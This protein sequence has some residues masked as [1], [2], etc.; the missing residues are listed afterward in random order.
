M[1]NCTGQ[2]QVVSAMTRM[3]AH[4]STCVSH[5][6]LGRALG[7]ANAVHEVAN[8]ALGNDVGGGVANLDGD[9]RASGETSLAVDGAH[10]H[11]HDEDNWVGAPGEDGGPA[12]PLDLLAASLRLRLL[13]LL[14]ANKEGVHDVAE[15][16]HGEEPEA[17][18]GARLA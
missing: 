13:G 3:A 4:C 10:E 18:P 1:T 8:A 17:P 5:L 11:R 12:C 15:W 14:E 16:E 2:Y 6:H 7:E 9:H